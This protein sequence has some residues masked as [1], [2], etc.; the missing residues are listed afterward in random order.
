MGSDVIGG[1][2]FVGRPEVDEV[3]DVGRYP[4][5]DAGS[6]TW[7]SVV[8]QARAELRRDGATVLPNVVRAELLERLR[9]EGDAVALDA[10]TAVAAVNVYNTDPDPG[11]PAEHP[12]RVVLTRRNA[13]VARDRIPADHLVQGLYEHP[14][15]R[16]LL[17]A[18]FELPDVHPLADP[19]SGLTLNVVAPGSDHPWHFDTNEIAVSL[20]TRAPKA[21]G[22]FE[23]CPVIRAPGAENLGRVRAVLDGDRGPV[24]SLEL[25]PGDLQLFRGRFAL[26]RVTTVAGDTSRHTTIFAYSD[27]PGVVGSPTRSRQLFGRVDPVHLAA[28]SARSD[29]LLD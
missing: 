24:R 7:E 1:A 11:L 20:L 28:A 3:V 29:T 14:G 8:E 25:R 6:P 15:F 23:Y 9:A 16:R 12:A 4:L 17:A 27:R 19:Y 21:G 10:H 2:G 5:D 13:F 26:H 18:C 22:S